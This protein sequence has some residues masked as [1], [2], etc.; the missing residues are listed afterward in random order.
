M[1]Q[2]NIEDV[3]SVLDRMSTI[4]DDTSKDV[5]RTLDNASKSLHN[6]AMILHS[7]IK[8]QDFKFKEYDNNAIIRS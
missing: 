3:I 8:P 4:L 1:Q 2:V 5:S 7:L 6:E